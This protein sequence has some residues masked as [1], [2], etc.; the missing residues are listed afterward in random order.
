MTRSLINHYSELQKKSKLKGV[1]FWKKISELLKTHGYAIP[2]S[3][4]KSKWDGLCRKYKNCLQKVKST[5]ASPPD[6]IFYD[7]MHN[8]MFSKPQ[9]NPPAIASNIRGYEKRIADQTKPENSN[10]EKKRK[11]EKKSTTQNEY[12]QKFISSSD[13]K[14]VIK[15]EKHDR[16][17]D[18]INN[19]ADAIKKK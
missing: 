1:L 10:E 17:I 18:A 13:E 19:L 14:F 2:H 8:I 3:K 15:M 16:M 7:K 11:I 12:I 6:F 5:G 9:I 4:C